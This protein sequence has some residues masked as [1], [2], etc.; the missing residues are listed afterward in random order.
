MPQTAQGAVS[1]GHSQA[2][3]CGF[4]RHHPLVPFSIFLL[5][6]FSSVFISLLFRSRKKREQS[7]KDR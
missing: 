6:L 3:I 7:G 5:H 1:T 4:P 2:A